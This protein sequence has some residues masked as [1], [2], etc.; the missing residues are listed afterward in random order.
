MKVV[1]RQFVSYSSLSLYGRPRGRGIVE[2]CVEGVV[3]AS[4]A[5]ANASLALQDSKLVICNGCRLTACTAT[6]DIRSQGK[7]KIR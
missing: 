3:S 2:R 1:N 5:S 7:T 6:L 4:V